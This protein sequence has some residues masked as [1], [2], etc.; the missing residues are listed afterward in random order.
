MMRSFVSVHS[1]WKFIAT[2]HSHWKNSILR[3]IGTQC[4]SLAESHP[5]AYLLVATTFALAGYACLLFFPWLVFRSVIGIHEVLFKSQ[6]LDWIHLLIWL[7]VAM[8]SIL[9]SYRIF[10]FR[11]ALPSGVVLNKNTAPMLFQLVADQTRHYGGTGIDRIVLTSDFELDIVKT[12]RCALPMWSSSTLVIGLPLLQCLSAPMFQCALASRL[13]Q[14]SRR[15]EWLENWL[16]QLRGIWPQYCAHEQGS[17]FGFQPVRWFFLIYAPIYK[18]ITVP[19]AHSN[20][21]AADKCAMELFNDDEMLDTITTQMVC[22][23]YLADEY[24]PAMQKIAATGKETAGNLYPSMFSALHKVLHSDKAAHWLKR[25]VSTENQW[26]DAMPS[27]TRRVENI[28]HTQAR[29]S[30]IVSKS[31]ANV[32]LA[33]A[34]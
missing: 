18:V 22:Y 21:L 20:E 26:D 14:L 28:G 31:A 30:T 29:I 17:V 4:Q 6:S 12:P 10:L 8:L 24:W 27:L 33:A 3:A 25:A 11:P 7:A 15:S 23:R 19:A 9:A 16:Y 34:N 1:A 2:P 32:Y 5:R 13:G